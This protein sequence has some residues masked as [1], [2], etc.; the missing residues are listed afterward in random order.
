MA[1]PGGLPHWTPRHSAHIL[2]A[3]LTPAAPA[4]RKNL[5]MGE[6]FRVRLYLN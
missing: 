5:P 2:A 6:L 1:L 4:M 3:L